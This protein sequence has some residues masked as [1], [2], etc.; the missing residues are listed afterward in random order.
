[1]AED[2]QLVSLCAVASVE[3]GT[4]IRIELEG[5]AY[6]VYNLEGEFFVTE[7]ECSHG[8]GSL[9]Q[10]FVLDD[11]IE[12]PLHQGRFHIP[13]GRPTEEP[14][15]EPIKVWKVTLVDGQVCIDPRET[16]PSG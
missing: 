9:S 5:R 16:Q 2:H 4:A 8:R 7:D 10:G 15:T 13:S 3:P 12:C 11:E 14:C 6:A 1:M